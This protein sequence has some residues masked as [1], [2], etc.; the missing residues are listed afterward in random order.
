[1]LWGELKRIFT[2]L[3]IL[4]LFLVVIPVYAISSIIIGIKQPDTTQ[5][6]FDE[7]LE[8][9][10]SNLESIIDFEE[11][12]YATE[13]AQAFDAF[14]DKWDPFFGSHATLASF[15]NSFCELN[16]AYIAF[17]Q[18]VETSFSG[19]STVLITGGSY[20][21]LRRGMQE[22]EK[23]IEF[24]PTFNA[25]TLNEFQLFEKRGALSIAWDN[26]AYRIPDIL[27][28]TQSLVFDW[29]QQRELEQLFDK[30][31]VYVESAADEQ[32]RM[33]FLAVA[34]EYIE[35]NIKLIQSRQTNDI[36]RFQ[37]FANFNQSATKDRLA[38]LEVLIT[39]QRA[40]SEYSTPYRF[41]HVL[42]AQTGT[43][44]M[45]FV[46]NNLELITIPLIVLSCLIVV[47]CIYSDIKKNTIIGSLVGSK[48]R[49]QVLGTKLLACTIAI[50]LL[51][52]IFALLFFLT[53]T[54]ITGTATAPMILTAFGGTAIQ[55]S[56]FLLLMVYLISLFFKILFFASITAL[57]CINAKSIIPIL[58][59]S[60]ATIAAIILLNVLFTIVWP[61][62]FY[63]Y[64]PLVALDFAGFFGV[65]FMLTRH[66]ASTFIWFTLP[67]MLIIWCAI[68][69]ATFRRFNR[70]D[71]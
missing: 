18:A 9:R 54:I 3:P 55:I 13:L 1:M 4:V 39:E 28:N 57:V 7:Q 58:I 51:I 8:I 47:F 25:N 21:A 49:R 67:I 60:G 19:T 40:S 45:D 5:Y 46:F 2:K 24:E 37:G 35:L 71:F 52:G 56:P 11:T 65:G 22:L 31:T 68:I 62:A 69:G 34:C 41:G 33:E 6:M 44:G 59:I 29:E 20:S 38:V 48:S 30:V 61:L 53:A 32:Q 36:T 12:N 14:T 23:S 50:A 42:H 10:F 27:R 16:S 15:Q 66:I 63:Q 17:A 70:R 26:Y 43:S 64:L